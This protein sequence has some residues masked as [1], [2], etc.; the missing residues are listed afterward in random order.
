MGACELLKESVFQL[1]WCGESN[2]QFIFAVG[3]LEDLQTTNDKCCSYL[4][5]DFVIPEKLENSFWSVGAYELL[6]ESGFQLFLCGESNYQIIFDF[7]IMED[8]QTVTNK[9]F[10]YLDHDF[11]TA[12]KQVGNKFLVCGSMWVTEREW[13]PTF[14]MWWIQLYSHFC[15]WLIGRSSNSKW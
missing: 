15:C 4:K 9:W 12:V 1:F 3:W 11:V 7:C 14:L 6:K 13:F 5:C 2:Y 10:S 8:F